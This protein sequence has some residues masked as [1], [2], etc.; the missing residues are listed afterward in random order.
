[1][2][3]YMFGGGNK[4]KEAPKKAIITLREQINM[5]TKKQ[6]HLYTQIEDQQNIAKKFISSDTVKAKNALKRKKVLDNEATKI[7][8]QI[9]ALENQLRSIES[10][11]LNLETMKAMKQGAKAMKQI[12]GGIT[13]DKVDQTMDDI[14]EQAELGEEISEAISR[15]YPGENV[16]EDE[17]ED[18]LEALQQEEIDNKLLNSGQ[19]QSQQQYSQPQVKLPDAPNTSIREDKSKENEESE[20]EDEKALKALQ[21]EMGL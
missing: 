17:L 7:S 21:A 1:M 16:D 11:N 18:E 2:W 13:V 10:A 20:D 6:N 8:S 19:K 5:L 3:S 4:D 15:S 12:H 14:R 9:D